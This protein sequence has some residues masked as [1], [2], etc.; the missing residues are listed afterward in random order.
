MAT[1]CLPRQPLL[2]AL[3]FGRSNGKHGR[4]IPCV[5]AGVLDG[6]FYRLGR[7]VR[8]EIVESVLCTNFVVR[9]SLK[10]LNVRSRSCK[11]H[12]P[13]RPIS[14]YWAPCSNVRPEF[15][16]VNLAFADVQ[17]QWHATKRI[18]S[19]HTSQG[20]TNVAALCNMCIRNDTVCCRHQIVLV[21]RGWVPESWKQQST[22]PNKATDGKTTQT[23][24]K[25]MIK[26]EGLVVESEKPSYFVPKNNPQTGEWFSIIASEIVFLTVLSMNRPYSL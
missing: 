9:R 7:S 25:G 20:S 19:D 17:C 8:K 26:V 1:C 23:A 4:C 3:D 11:G 16:V 12:A 24:D 13:Q 2:A 21:N 18:H 5:D 14:F 15:I 10:R 6:V 22:A